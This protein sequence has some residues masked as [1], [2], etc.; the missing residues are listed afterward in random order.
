MTPQQK[1]LV[2]TSF[3]KVMPI[4]DAAAQ[5]FYT[6]LFD[7]HPEVRPLFKE[8]MAVQGRKLMDML[9]VCVSKLDTLDQ[10]VPA[11]EKLGERHGRYQVRP[12]HFPWVKDALMDT[13]A[14]GLGAEFTPDVR[15]AWNTLYDL[16]A[17][18]MLG[19]VKAA[20][21]A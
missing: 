16:L 8:D 9:L 20:T 21:P 17:K 2:K 13:L 3:A 7:R 11:V 5:L 14:E 12:E 10:V 19:G 18:T 1:E 4:S 15:A 6:K